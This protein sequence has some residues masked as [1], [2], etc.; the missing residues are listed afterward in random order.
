MVL[1]PTM[2][3]KLVTMCP[4]RS[5]TKPDPDPCGTS[6]RFNDQKSRRSVLLVI[7]TTE[8]EATSNTA[9]VARSSEPS[10]DGG[11]ASERAPAS[12]LPS[13][14]LDRRSGFSSRQEETLEAAR[15]SSR[16]MAR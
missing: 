6:K 10:S 1:A 15:A 3:W 5:Q 9:I 2:T 4:W 13:S 14:A 12:D 8:R 11:G 16:E 7:K